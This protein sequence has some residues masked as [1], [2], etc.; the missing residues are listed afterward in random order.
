MFNAIRLRPLNEYLYKSVTNTLIMTK[1]PYTDKFFEER[2]NS[3]KAAK[4]IVPLILKLIQPK[5]VVDVGCG[6]GEFLYV[7]K[8]NGVKEILGIDGEWVNRKKLRIPENSFLSA[9]LEKPLKIDK[10]FDLVVSLEVAE[11]LPEKSAKTF[12]ETLTNLGQLILFSAAI[13]FQGGTHHVNER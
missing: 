2:I 3:L 4:H 11:H 10:K 5:N 13:P 8:E 12:I 7:F 1:I 9:N 6:T